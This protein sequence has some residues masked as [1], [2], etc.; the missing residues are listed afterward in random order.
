MKYSDSSQGVTYLQSSITEGNYCI[1]TSHSGI[2]VK[3]VDLKHKENSTRAKIGFSNCENLAFQFTEKL[4]ETLEMT[5]DVTIL[6]KG[7]FN[8]C[9][10]VL[11]KYL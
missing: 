9:G 4:P 1:K 3:I 7:H 8:F 5:A 2:T 6:T 10:K 11:T